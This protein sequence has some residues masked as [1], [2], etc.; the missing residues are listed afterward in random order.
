M[1]HWA[2]PDVVASAQ[3][4]DPAAVE[5]LIAEIWPRCFR[6]AASI[7]GDRWLAEDIAQDACAIVHRK[8]RSIRNPDAFDGW[9]YRIVLREALRTRRRS[10]IH[11]DEIPDTACA[12]LDQSHIDTW[13]ALDA[14]P[15]PMRA[16]VVLFYFDDLK[17]EE[18]A[19]ILGVAHSTVRTRLARAREQLRTMLGEPE[20]RRQGSGVDQHAY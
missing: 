18:I 6:L 5:R 4:G 13:R 15:A 2:P 12:V 19:S 9:V 16:V 8:Y 17:T 14:L 11:S 7:V 10:P 1:T 3:T 20:S